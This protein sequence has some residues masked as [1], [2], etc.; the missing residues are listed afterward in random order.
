MWESL[1]NLVLFL[2]VYSTRH[3]EEQKIFDTEDLNVR[4]GHLK[5]SFSKIPVKNC[6]LKNLLDYKATHTSLKDTAAKTD[7]IVKVKERVRNK[8]D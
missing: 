8:I 1:P 5:L 7:P 4:N 6:K 3:S 2:A